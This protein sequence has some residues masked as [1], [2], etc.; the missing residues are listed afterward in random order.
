M[1][2][3]TE[4][5]EIVIEREGVIMDNSPVLYSDYWIRHGDKAIEVRED[6]DIAAAAVRRLGYAVGD[7]IRYEIRIRPRGK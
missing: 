5:K 1:A 4:L 6:H 7:R 2:K 3:K